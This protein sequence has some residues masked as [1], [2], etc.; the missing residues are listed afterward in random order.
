[1]TSD[2]SER[3]TSGSFFVAKPKEGAT[4]NDL[5]DFLRVSG[6][7]IQREYERIYKRVR[8]DPG[9]AGD[10]GEENWRELLEDWMPANYHVVTKGRILFADGKSSPQFDVLMLHPAYPKKLLNKKHYLAG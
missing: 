5:L 7:E 10:Q 6:E 8:E 3:R 2:P 1:M 4:N 9:T